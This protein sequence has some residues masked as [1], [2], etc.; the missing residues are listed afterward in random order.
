MRAKRRRDFV[1]G[2]WRAASVENN[3]RHTGDLVG[4]ESAVCHVVFLCEGKF[5]G[6]LPRDPVSAVTDHY[7]IRAGALVCHKQLRDE[8]RLSAVANS[9][10]S[11]VSKVS[12]WHCSFITRNNKE[13]SLAPNLGR[14]GSRSDLL[15]DSGRAIRARSRGMADGR[16]EERAT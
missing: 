5:R 10:R 3:S 11:E 9:S 1:G 6:E 13:A 15:I 2:T 8:E 16:A 7:E 4:R 12:D 14:R